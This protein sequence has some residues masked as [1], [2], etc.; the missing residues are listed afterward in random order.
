MTKKF[1]KFSFLRLISVGWP[2][3]KYRLFKP[4][5]YYLSCIVVLFIAIISNIA[6]FFL[7]EIELCKSVMTR[8]FTTE[9]WWAVY[10]LVKEVLTRILPIVLLIFFNIILI[11]IV[12]S[13]RRKMKESISV[14]LSKDSGGKLKT[15][16]TFIKC[17]MLN[18]K[19]LSN[20]TEDPSKLLLRN[21]ATKRNR[22][23]NQLTWMTIFVAILY[24]TSSIPM[25][26]AYPGLIFKAEQTQTRVYKMY[27]VLVNILELLQC[28]FRFLI[29]YCFTTKFRQVFHVMYKLERKKKSTEMTV[30]E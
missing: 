22:Q 5:R 1:F 3:Q 23:E 18:N 29:Y 27:A 8:S 26:F 6:N 14:S 4:S 15:K 9:G 16:F 24:S 2:T 20:E 19:K 10:G 21:T 12:K 17:F 7:Y 13:S 11:C 28:S 25:V 30:V